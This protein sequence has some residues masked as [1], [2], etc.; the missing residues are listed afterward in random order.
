MMNFLTGFLLILATFLGGMNAEASVLG[1]VK[2][3]KQIF[4]S[5]A[6]DTTSKSAANSGRDYASAKGFFDGDLM[7]IPANVIITNVYEVVDVAD[8]GLTAFNLGDDDASTGFVASSGAAFA[9]A[10]LYHWG[11][12]Y[13][14]AYLK[15]GSLGANTYGMQA[16]HYSATGKE[17][18]IDVTGTASSTARM[19]VIVEGYGV[20]ASGL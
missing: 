20:G 7:A 6:V 11:V 5:G 2:F 17:L 19:R 16:K 12:D 9:S 8:S 13:K 3:Q 15:G 4:L 10:G 14:G 1:N 18:K